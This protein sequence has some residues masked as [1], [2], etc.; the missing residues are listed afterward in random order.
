MSGPAAAIRTTRSPPQDARR[1]NPPGEMATD[2][3]QFGDDLEKGLPH[4]V[5][6]DQGAAVGQPR[7]PIVVPLTGKKAPKQSENGYR[8][9]NQQALK[10]T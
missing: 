10:P 5:R 7:E 6:D 3:R 8:E 4:R 9:E 1:S 2:A